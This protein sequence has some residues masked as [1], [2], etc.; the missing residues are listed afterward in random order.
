MGWEGEEKL[1]DDESPSSICYE[2]ECIV[3]NNNIN[4][5][6]RSLGGWALTGGSTCPPNKKKISFIQKQQK[7]RAHRSLKVL[8]M[9]TS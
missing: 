7:K 8:L 6:T 3:I 4:V 2:R 9:L 5:V 1:E